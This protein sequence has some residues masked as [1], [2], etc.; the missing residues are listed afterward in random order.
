M[1]TQNDEQ[2]S[3]VRMHN[4]ILL[5]SEMFTEAHERFLRAGGDSDYVASLLLSG[6]VVGVVAPLLK[7][8]GTRSMHQLLAALS[9][10]VTEPSDESAHEGM[11]RAVYNGIKHAGNRN[12]GVAASQDL[13]IHADLR[14]EAAE[15]LEAAREDFRKV[16]VDADVQ[17]SLSPKFLAILGSGV[18]YA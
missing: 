5:A 11:F 6:A 8:Q 14:V 15:M 3:S 17:S 12:K 1:M 9:D 4:K 2:G 10:I 13:M 18:D 7:E 16:L